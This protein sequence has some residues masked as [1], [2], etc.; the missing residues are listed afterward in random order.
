MDPPFTLYHVLSLQIFLSSFLLHSVAGFWDVWGLLLVL[1]VV[2]CFMWF[3]L[4]YCFLF[5]KL[6][7]RLLG[8]L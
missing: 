5:L 7:V 2:L 4:L 8:S 6:F 3:F 1:A